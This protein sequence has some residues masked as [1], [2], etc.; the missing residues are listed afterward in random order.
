MCI[1]AQQLQVDFPEVSEAA[2]LRDRIIQEDEVSI[3]YI[4]IIIINF[5]LNIYILFLNKY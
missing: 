2:S 5:F 3:L 1:K 4:Y